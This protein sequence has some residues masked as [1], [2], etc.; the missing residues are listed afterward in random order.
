MVVLILLLS[1]IQLSSCASNSY[2]GA[3]VNAAPFL[4]RVQ[5]QQL[6]HLQVSAAV[7]DYAETIALT[8]LDLYKQGIQPVWLKIHNTGTSRARV[9]NWSIDRDYFSPVEVAYKNRK[10]FNGQAYTELEQWFYDNALPRYIPPGETR[11]GLVF[12]HLIPGTKGFNLDISSNMEVTSFTFFI[13]LP[14]FTADHTVVDFSTLYTVDE[15]QNFNQTELRSTLEQELACC[16]T[17]A[18]GKLAGGPINSVLVGS[19]ETVRRALLRGGWQETSIEDAVVKHARRHKFHDRSPDTIFYIDREDGNERLQLSLWLAPWKVDGVPVWV[20]QV[21][22]RNQDNKLLASLKEIESLQ[23]SRLIKKFVA[24][25][26]MADMD[27]AQNF[28]LQNFWYNHSLSKT[29]L[30]EGAGTSTVEEPRISFDGVAYFTKGQRIVIFLSHTPVALDDAKIIYTGIEDGT[31]NSSNARAKT[32]FEGKQVKPPNN[33]LHI[34]TQDFLTVATAVPSANECN[35]IFG[36]NLYKKNIQPVWVQVENRGDKALFLTPMGLDSSYYTHREMAQR[37]RPSGNTID[38]KSAD[39]SIG[40]LLIPPHSIQSG[41]VFSRVDEGTKSFNV[42]VVGGP[43]PYRMSFFV[44]VPGLKLDHYEVD[45]DG[46]YSSAEISDVNLEGLIA[47]LESMPCC[48]RDATGQNKGDPLNLVFVGD[49]KD[50]YYAFMRAGWDETETIYGSSLLKTAKSAMTG[51]RYR[52]SPVSAL[53][54]FGRAQDI[55]LQ[56][57]RSSIHQR[58]HLRLW[59]TPLKLEGKPIWIGQISRDIGVRLT[60]STITTHKIDPDVDE[61]REFLLEDLAYAE[62]V[63]KFGYVGGTGAAPYHHPRGNLTGDPYFTDG[64][65]II[66]WISGAPI[67]IGEIEALNLTVYSASPA[68]N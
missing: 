10:A 28:L 54:V 18:S 52:Y 51:V 11:S 3:D 21:F 39:H 13:P 15:I 20:G 61:T 58:N 60:W 27:S 16:T 12:T 44:P 68:K 31:A 66:M 6:N 63:E 36:T 30:V 48:V 5:T 33:R 32:V 59:L 43:N 53:Y 41:Y 40:K 26:V 34:Q 45:I 14:G 56:R 50:M 19:P 22:Y 8:G 47:K 64:Q 4:A 29:G 35:D 67:A 17:N 62:A 23:D 46:L 7:P 57:T 49:V 9:S 42:D 25:S 2:R 1:V 38:Q 24:E 55:A 37:R 65:R